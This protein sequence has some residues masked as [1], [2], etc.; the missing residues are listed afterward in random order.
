MS[1]MKR[2]LFNREARDE[3]RRMGGI[4]ASSEPL[5]MAAAQ[6]YAPG[7][8]VSTDMYVISVPGVLTNVGEYLTVSSQTLQRL[9]DLMPDVMMRAAQGENN[10]FVS[11]VESASRR[12]A[13][14]V[15]AARPGDAVVQTRLNRMSQPS[16]PAP[17]P[18]DDRTIRDIVRE[19]LASS[20]SVGP[21]EALANQIAAQGPAPSPTAYGDIK[22]GQGYDA[23]SLFGDGNIFTNQGTRA[24]GPPM[25]TVSEQLMNQGFI[26]G[27]IDPSDINMPRPVTIGDYGRTSVGPNASEIQR[28]NETL[29]VAG[30]GPA[31]GYQS[32]PA[33]TTRI[34]DEVDETVVASGVKRGDRR[35]KPE[36][37]RTLSEIV[38]GVLPESSDEGVDATRRKQPKVTP[39]SADA[40]GEIEEDVVEETTTPKFPTLQEFITL[41]GDRDKREKIQEKA[42]EVLPEIDKD[43]KDADTE[44]KFDSVFDKYVE[45]FTKILGEDPKEAEKDQGFAMAIFGATLASTGD[46][47][48]ATANMLETL[49]GD[50]A[51]R[52]ERKDKIKMLALQAGL[53]E[54]SERRKLARLDAQRITDYEDAIKLYE[55]KLK[56]KDRYDDPS[57]FL[58]TA[59]GRAALQ[60]Y[61][62][63]MGDENLNEE[64]RLA[65][66][67]SRGGPLVQRLLQEFP[68]L[69]GPS[70]PKQGG[71]NGA[72]WFNKPSD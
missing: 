65:S 64:D 37:R 66:A 67:V 1:V 51:T 48:Q 12:N 34:G 38:A 20:Y 44:E 52:Q 62:S 50:A 41:Q 2:K 63:A 43:I 10:G 24:G 49:R 45:K 23:A 47:G 17:V 30:I 28:M 57:G 54:E 35:D 68:G 11:D 55:T 72:D 31:T 40:A 6:G 27:D 71:G 59:E 14:V 21:L 53:D 56:I 60:I 39:E 13:A 25:P 61:L 15:R 22:P 32:G 33:T 36:V 18:T 29:D 8:Q 16:E 70:Q 4:M 7:G 5:M 19:G 46:F 9:N 26:G 3:L 42:D 58:D 69:G